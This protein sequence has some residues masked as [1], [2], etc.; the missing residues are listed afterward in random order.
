MKQ[1]FLLF[2]FDFISSFYPFYLDWLNRKPSFLSSGNV[3]KQK[4]TFGFILAI[5]YKTA[6]LTNQKEE[7]LKYLKVVP[8]FALVKRP[9]SFISPT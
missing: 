6:C 5:Y 9:A 4:R 1:C 7:S 8:T 2:C 3:Q